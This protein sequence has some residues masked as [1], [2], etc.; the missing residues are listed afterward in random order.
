MM[1]EHSNSGVIDLMF[2]KPCSSNTK[3]TEDS[4]KS[5]SLGLLLVYF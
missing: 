5:G 3:E 4:K 1:L 2:N